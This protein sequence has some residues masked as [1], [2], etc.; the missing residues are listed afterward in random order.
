LI[1]AL[2][3]QWVFRAVLIWMASPYRPMLRF[4]WNRLRTLSSFSSWMFVSTLMGRLMDHV[5]YFIV[6]RFLGTTALGYYS[7]A[8]QMVIIPVQR[9]IGVLIMVL[10]PS[11]VKIK[12]DTIRLKNGFLYALKLLTLGLI[13]ISAFIFIAADALVPLLYSYKWLPSIPVVRLL[14]LAGFFYGLDLTTSLLDAVGKP[15]WRFIVLC[16]R[17]STFILVSFAWGLAHGIEGVAVSILVA[18]ALSTILQICILLRE[19]RIKPLTI[20]R[21]F[22][23]PISSI[24][25]AMILVGWFNNIINGL[26]DI[27]IVTTMALVFAILYALG[28]LLLGN[29]DD[30]RR[31]FSAFRYSNKEI[32]NAINDIHA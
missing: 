23:L 32:P 17:V 16:F 24:L 7:I 10:F 8:F 3:A 25:P 29:R 22:F 18:V 28:V 19:M 6:G 15:K 21:M 12:N 30:L 26:S 13:P 27:L 5:D 4:E 2:A 14:A 9:I 20:F 31:I 1:G 11:F